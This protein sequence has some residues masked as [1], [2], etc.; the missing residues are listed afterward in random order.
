MVNRHETRLSQLEVY[1]WTLGAK[2]RSRREPGLGFSNGPKIMTWRTCVPSGKSNVA[3]GNPL[4]MG[5]WMRQ[6]LKKTGW[7]FQQTTFEYTRGCMYILYY[8]I[9]Y[10]VILLYYSILYYIMWYYYIIVYYIILYHIIY[11]RTYCIMGLIHPHTISFF[12]K[13]HI[14]WTILKPPTD[15]ACSASAQD[16]FAS[17]SELRAH[18]HRVTGL[19]PFGQT[20]SSL[21]KITIFNG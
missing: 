2:F 9:L 17:I 12:F 3:T 7:F 1:D 11:I 4:S 8:I 6:S 19:I 5:V 16:D 13:C 10:Y 15:P 14:G 21:W 18:I 20:N